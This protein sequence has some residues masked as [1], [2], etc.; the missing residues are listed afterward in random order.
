[1]IVTCNKYIVAHT[2]LHLNLPAQRWLFAKLDANGPQI[3]SS[4]NSK[5]ILDMKREKDER[6][7]TKKKKKKK[8]AST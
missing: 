7:K 4:K 6:L 8:K 3:T 5:R 1:M 2:P